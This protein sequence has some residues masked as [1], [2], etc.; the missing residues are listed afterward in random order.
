MISAL[1]FNIHIHFLCLTTL[2]F[3]KMFGKS[4]VVQRLWVHLAVPPGPLHALNHGYG[5]VFFVRDE[6]NFQSSHQTLYET[7]RNEFVKKQRNL[8]K[9]KFIW[10]FLHLTILLIVGLFICLLVAV[11]IVVVI[12]VAEDYIWTLE[13]VRMYQ[14]A[15]K[16]H[17]MKSF[18][19][20]FPN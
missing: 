6:L 8:R 20:C 14:E 13:S 11:V 2:L 19:I 3:S 1:S 15:G 9:F 17:I 10:W 4:Y 5:N 12:L 18:I 16:N 7:G